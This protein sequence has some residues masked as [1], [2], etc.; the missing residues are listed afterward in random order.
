MYCTF[1]CYLIFPSVA[2]VLAFFLN[3][4]SLEVDLI[5]YIIA[6]TTLFFIP[7]FYPENQ[8]ADNISTW[9][10]K[11]S[12]A[13]QQKNS[14]L[15]NI[16]QIIDLSITSQRNSSLNPSENIRLR[17]YIPRNTIESRNASFSNQTLLKPILLWIHGWGFIMGS[18]D[19]DDMICTKLSNITQFIVVNVE[20][21]LAP[22]FKY[23]LAIHDIIDSLKWIKYGRMITKYGGDP[24]KVFIA[25]TG[26]GGTLAAATVAVINDNKLPEYN[27][28]DLSSDIQ[29]L[30]LIY[31]FL[32]P[33]NHSESH[34]TFSQFNG[35]LT[36][37]EL[38]WMW[39]FYLSSDVL[40]Q[41]NHCQHY[42]ACPMRIP[43]KIL[44]KFPHTVVILA[45]NDVVFDEGVQ[46][47]QNLTNVKVA[48][49]VIV[50]NSTIHGFFGR[51]S[52]GLAA[53]DELG[54]RLLGISS[55]ENRGKYL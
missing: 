15:Q 54:A 39:S 29:G 33:I 16:D 24:S 27:K 1:C 55:L 21:R 34:S 32:E 48:T 10:N 6:K 43:S 2:V 22:E 26:S 8:N 13:S 35:L 3:N 47:A 25:G 23:P 14:Y 9:R 5:S 53:V 28:Y 37:R 7:R 19:N 38:Q 52:N 50:Y 4:H 44:K 42:S 17:L 30:I 12:T 45:G 49:E 51:F 18:T 40:E 41:R 36:L 31:P 46:F 20:Y 11:L